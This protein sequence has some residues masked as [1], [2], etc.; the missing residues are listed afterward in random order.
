[1]RRRKGGN[2]PVM[3]I[4]SLFTAAATTA[5]LVSAT[6]VASAS[7]NTAPA[8]SQPPPPQ[9]ALLTFVPPSVG[10]ICVTIG[11][12]IIGGQIISPGV[13]VCT[14]GVSLPP[15]TLPAQG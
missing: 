10:P 2:V 13:H 14:S 9:S 1:V 8:A 12:I 6:S 7:A 4:R 11:P 3:S 15:L 5:V